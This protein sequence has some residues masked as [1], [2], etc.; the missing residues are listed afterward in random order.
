MWGCTTE[1]DRC[2]R[3]LTVL[4]ISTMGNVTESINTATATLYLLL[5]YNIKHALKNNQ[6]S[7]YIIIK[8]P[9]L[10]KIHYK[11]VS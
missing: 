9:V 4:L 10:D 7:V 5:L 11:S 1:R 2:A 3:L 8:L 6:I